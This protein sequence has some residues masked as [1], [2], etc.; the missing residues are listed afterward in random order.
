MRAGAT[1]FVSA[2]YT[3]LFKSGRALMN[4][5]PRWVDLYIFLSS[6]GSI[7]ESLGQFMSNF[8][9]KLGFRSGLVLVLLV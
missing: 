6:I 5:G 7:F 9:E 2:S 1:N 3:D 8:A 4:F